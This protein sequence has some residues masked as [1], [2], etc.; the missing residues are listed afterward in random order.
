MKVYFDTD[1]LIAAF[2]RTHPHH[3]P[4]IDLLDGACGGALQG[5]ISTHGLGEFYS[6]L[7]RTP[8]TPRVRPLEAK[9]FLDE[10][11]SRYF[12][13]V[14]LTETDYATVLEAGLVGGMIFDALHLCAAEKANCERIYTFNVRH[15][16]PLASKELAGKITAP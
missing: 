3:G 12:E 10:K 2:V 4:A 7:T 11:I 8:F 15:F 9:R 1:V 14:P 16:R 5:C 6:V 13:I